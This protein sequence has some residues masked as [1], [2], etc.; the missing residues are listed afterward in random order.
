MEVISKH[1]YQARSSVHPVPQYLHAWSV[2][3]C[4][5]PPPGRVSG[6]VEERHKIL[7]LLFNNEKYA[8]YKWD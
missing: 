3:H 8:H 2:I 1:T 6:S 7:F 4:T 5:A